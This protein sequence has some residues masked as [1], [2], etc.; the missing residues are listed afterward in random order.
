MSHSEQ[1]IYA[2]RGAQV[3][4]VIQVAGDYYQIFCS[5]RTSLKI[6]IRSQQ[7]GSLFEDRVRTL[8]GREY[9]FDSVRRM[10]SGES[11]SS[12][13]ILIR[14]QP[15]IGKTTFMC[16][17]LKRWGCVHHFN[18]EQ[19]N[20]RSAR[21]FL[22]NVCAQIIVRYGLEYDTL[23]DDAGRD[24]GFLSEVLREASTKTT[25]PVLV[26][27]DALDEAEDAPTP[28]ANRLFLPP[29]LPDRVHIVVTTREQIDYRLQVDRRQDL[30][31]GNND[32]QNLADVREYILGALSNQPD[33]FEKVLAAWKQDKDGFAN[34]IADRSQ[35]NF[36]YLVHVLR[37]VR[38]GRITPENLE[39]VDELPL[40]LS[41]YYQRHWRQMREMDRERFE[42]L[43]E[44][45]LR[46]LATAREPVSLNALSQWS[47]ASPAMLREVIEAWRPFLT[48][49]VA[50]GEKR[51]ALYHASFRDFLAQE[52]VGLQPSHLRIIETALAKIALAK[53]P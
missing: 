29:S 32:P 14:G 33:A 44:P 8:V 21:T 34:L 6:A 22:E 9:L 12:G 11:T 23:P 49:N 36:M 7:F 39:S 19:Q 31:I 13:Y 47:G 37:D 2:D 40:G 51:Y 45:A 17:L 43:F 18:I 5:S 1:N 30:H 50:Q 3:R 52:G 25:E 16:L 15:G 42:F 35:G 41:A 4:D 10:V 26:L 53:S 28:V 38:E 46:L 24:S 27:I 48:E 20:I